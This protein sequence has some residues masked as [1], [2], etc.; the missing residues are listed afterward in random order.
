MEIINFKATDV[1][2][3]MQQRTLIEAVR[4]YLLKFPRVGEFSKMNIDYLPEEA[5]HHSISPLPSQNGGIISTTIAG[6]VTKEYMFSFSTRFPYEERVKTH[7]ENSGFL[8]EFVEWIE[9]N[10]RKGVLPNLPPY[11]EVQSIEV[12]Q[13]PSLYFTADGRT[14]E[15][16]TTLRL[17]YFERR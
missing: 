6:D 11:K 17:V 7:I 3:E 8:E 10:N 12:V 4:D 16:M 13:T 15:Y 5:I 14:A 2:I 9:G 1:E